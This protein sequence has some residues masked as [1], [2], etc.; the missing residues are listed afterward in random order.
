[1]EP[2]SE[3]RFRQVH[4]DFH[5]SPHIP[6]IG[7]DFDAERFV[8]TLTKAH[9]NS[10]TC[11]SR[12]HHGYIYHDTKFPNRHPHLKVNLLAEQIR[13][14]HAADIKVPIYITVGWD[15]LVATEHP[16]WI[17]I[18][19]EGRQVGRRP[20]HSAWGWYKLDNASP[21]LDYVIKQTEEVL[22]I[23]GD[24]VDGL[25]FDII[26]QTGVHSVWCLDRF[27]RLGWDP[28]DAAR[29]AEMKELLVAECTDR[30]A[31]SVRQKR[32]NCK[33]FFNSGHVGPRFQRIARNYSH[34][35]IES[36]PTGG[37]GYMHFPMTVRYARTL[38]KEYLGMTGRFSEM[39]GHFNSYKAPAALEFECLSMLAQGAKC[40]V[41]DQ[42]HPRGALDEATYELIGP[43]YAKVEEREPWCTGAKAVAE[44]GVINSE[45]FD[46]TMERMD[47]RNLGASRMLIEGKHQFD[48]IDF[49]AN[50][51]DYKVLVLPDVTPIDDASRAKLQNYLDEGGSIIASHKSGLNLPGM[52][53]KIA[54]DLEFSPDFIRPN[55]AIHP[56]DQTD[57]VMYER[58]FEVEPYSEATVL[59]RISVPYFERSTDYFISHAH[60][61]VEKSTET[62]AV[63]K[64]GNVVYFAHPIFTTYAKH[65][66]LFHR[67]IVLAALAMILPEP[68]LK[69]D[70]PSALQATL[71]HQGENAI[72][73]LLFYIPERRGL[74]F[75][76]V[77]DALPIRNLPVHIR[78]QYARARLVP[79]NI[80]LQ[81]RHEG[82][83]TTVIVPS[84]VGHQMIEFTP[85]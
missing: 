13:A 26:F 33:M 24:E 73:H 49:E 40:S 45:G 82:S 15:H 55:K 20:I 61:P 27:R 76:I 84:M 31:R 68:A 53:G 54:G 57:F 74:N 67:D 12:C 50:L 37:W 4:L 19:I 25:F 17:E 5:T 65:S 81:V 52:P 6:E 35:E 7:A 80:E 14:C 46:A 34:L 30:I 42:L 51:S 21:Y 85:Q 44:I 28:A 71:T 69:V 23:F 38:G 36:L 10:I 16:E 32:P 3:L 64:Y 72:A 8:D 29:Q 11:F 1:M 18:D 75:E 60:T 62:P 79:E 22:D 83:Y 41:G 58:G 43:V 78:G 63:I 59:G 56:Q 9:V 39:W 77:E 47:P 70:G 2:N 66:M 48:L